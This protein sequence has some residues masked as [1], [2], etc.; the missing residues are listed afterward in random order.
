VSLAAWRG[1]A[2]PRG[3]PKAV[4]SAL[5]AAIRRTA[6]SSDFAQACEKIGVHP[7]FMPATE[8]GELIAREDVELARIMQVIGLK[9]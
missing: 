9:K 2:A 8:F 1:I 5:E 7:A 3:T 6:E 4:V